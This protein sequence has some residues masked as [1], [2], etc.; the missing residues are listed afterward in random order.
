MSFR[1]PRFATA[2]P[3][4]RLEARLAPAVVGY[5]DM[6]LGQG[7]TTQVYPIQQAGH[8]PQPLTDLTANDLVNVDVLVVQNPSNSSYGAE[9]L[10]R[11]DSIRDFVSRGKTLILH[12][13]Y[14]DPAETILPGASTFDIRRNFDDANNLTVLA[15]SNA[16]P[17]TGPG[18]TI[19]NGTLDG[20]RNSS[21]GYAVAASL[22]TGTQLILSTGTAANVVAFAYRFGRGYVYYAA[23]PLDFQLTGP[24]N[25]RNVYAVNVIAYGADLLNLAPVAAASSAAGDEDTDLEGNLSATDGDGDVLTYEI[26]TAPAHG[27]VT[28]LDAATGR[29]RYT[30]AAN[31][32]GSDSFT[33]R[34]G[35]GRDVSSAATVALTV[36]P[37]NDP[38]AVEA[39][40]DQAADEGGV[41]AFAATGSDGEG[42]ALTYAW[43]FGD[44]T[45][46]SGVAVEHAFR[47]NGVYTVRVTADDGNG[48]VA[49]DT[50]TVTVSNVAPVGVNAGADQ[51]ARVGDVVT[52]SG[53]FSDP[54]SG[55]THTLTW[56]VADNSGIVGSGSGLA[57]TFSPPRAGTFTVTFRVA[58]DDGGAAADTLVLTVSPAAGATATIAGPASAARG[59]RRE[60]TAGWSGLGDGKVQVEWAVFDPAGKRVAKGKG[61]RLAFTPAVEGNFRVVLTVRNAQGVSATAERLLPVRVVDVQPDP[62][63]ATKTALVVGGTNKG[64]VI[65]FRP[66][67]EVGRVE[68]VFG[69]TSLGSFVVDGHL[70]AYGGNG[71]DALTVD[72]ALTLPAILRGGNGKDVLTG[73]GGADILQGG[74]GNDVLNGGAGRDLLIGGRGSDVLRGGDGDDL[75]VGGWTTFG[76]NLPALAAVLAEW[77]SSRDFAT[78]SNNV[79]GK[80]VTADRLNGAVFLVTQGKKRTVFVEGCEDLHGEGGDNLLLAK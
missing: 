37:V 11:L 7:N 78:R 35:D 53:S 50:L 22:P 36:R 32:Y 8:T 23:I 45:S 20:G 59:Q 27:T 40:A 54:G 16:L 18:G 24:N 31:Y 39:G 61:T 34:A 66:S 33:F 80:A 9:Y 19:D 55:D 64:D 72:A 21:H 75:L 30:P 26:L 6:S 48:G 25:F 67:A 73:G 4:E 28:L 58:D 46:A 47:D 65:T 43:D 68:V 15:P 49:T 10:S 51:A 77:T 2:V 79:T 17:I 38:P 42:D 1:T 3:L 63:D 76:G 69:G 56:E 13:R 70:I 41:V 71:Q 52:F 60:F 29:Y 62:I 44:G 5:Y 12:D 14:V 57:W 74:N